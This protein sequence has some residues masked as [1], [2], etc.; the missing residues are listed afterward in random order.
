MTVT[1]IIFVALQISTSVFFTNKHHENI[2]EYYGTENVRLLADVIA[3]ER[4]KRIS[5]P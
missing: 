2:G 3:F 4:N 5:G 1:I